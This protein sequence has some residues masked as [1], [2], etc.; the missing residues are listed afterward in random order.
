M[1][2]RQGQKHVSN[3]LLKLGVRDWTR[4]VPRALELGLLEDQ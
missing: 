1:T 2:S 3:V 4:A